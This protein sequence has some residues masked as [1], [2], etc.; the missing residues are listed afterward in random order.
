MASILVVDDSPL[1][2]GQIRTCLADLGHDLR[3]SA[4]GADALAEIS[5]SLPDL[6]LLDLLM[7][8]VGGIDVLRR[9]E[10]K[11]FTPPTIV[12]TLNVHDSTRERCSQ[13][14]ARGVLEKPLDENELRE[15]V[16]RAVGGSR[17]A[18]SGNPQAPPEPRR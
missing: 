18:V 17:P 15:A 6:I 14:G 13:L 2:R 9:L 1:V 8:E 10:Q 7:P 5:R 4:G 16:F 3:E 11:G 12:L